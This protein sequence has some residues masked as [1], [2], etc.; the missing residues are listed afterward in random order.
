MKLNATETTKTVTPLATIKVPFQ[1][2]KKKL[3]GKKKSQL[4]QNHYN[5]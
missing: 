1:I 3:K 5:S 2:K 4:K